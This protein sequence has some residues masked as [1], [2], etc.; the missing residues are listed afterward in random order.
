MTLPHAKKR[1]NF[2]VVVGHALYRPWTDILEMGQLK[3]WLSSNPEIVKHSFGHPVNKFLRK[4]DTLFWK[5]KWIPVIG[6]YFL[7]LQR[8]FNPILSRIQPV[9]RENFQQWVGTNVW[10]VSCPDLDLLMANKTIAVLRNSLNHEYDHL[11]TTTSSSYINF[12]R[13]KEEIDLLPNNKCVAGRIV[14][15]NNNRFASGTFRIF[16]RDVVEEIVKNQFNFAYWLPEDLALGRALSLIPDIQWVTL[17]SINLQDINSLE[18][19]TDN[20]LKEVV[21]FRLTSGTLKNRNDVGIMKALHSRL[22]AIK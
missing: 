12:Q 14:Q 22:E 19:L 15:Q 2:I 20:S 21:H 1:E 13:L 5:I 18:N 6:K 11:I 7:G 16:S 4:I 17:N 9:V 8:G 3:T 10:E